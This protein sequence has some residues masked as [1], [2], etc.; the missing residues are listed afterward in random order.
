MELAWLA[1]AGNYVDAPSHMQSSRVPHNYVNEHLQFDELLDLV[2]AL[3][4]LFS[5]LFHGN[6]MRHGSRMLSAA[7]A[8]C[9]RQEFFPIVN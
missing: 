1:S 3:L 9:G 4:I 7:G 8:G 6:V 2:L 5:L